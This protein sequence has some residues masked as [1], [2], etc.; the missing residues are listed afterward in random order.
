[1]DYQLPIIDFGTAVSFGMLS[2]NY[3]RALGI[4]YNPSV[5]ILG[6]PADC[7]G[8]VGLFNYPPLGGVAMQ[9]R[10]TSPNDIVGG[11]GLRTLALTSLNPS[12]NAISGLGAIP[13]NGTT[14]V[15]LSSVTAAAALIQAN[16]GMRGITAGSLGTNDGDIILEAAGAPGGTMYGIIK[17]RVGTANQAPYVV[18]AGFTLAVPSLFFNVNSP[19]GGNTKFAQV[20]TWFRFFTGNDDGC[21]IQPLV[22]GTNNGNPYLHRADD[23]PIMLPEKTQFSLRVSIVSDNATAVTAAWNGFL[24]KNS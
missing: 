11:T 3:S 23:A 8:G 4:G 22:V 12:Y 21:A 18:P 7:W 5:D 6:T 10:S 9:V 17:A 1:M 2:P 20:R 14:P 13:M 24:R 16:N 15:L 19:G